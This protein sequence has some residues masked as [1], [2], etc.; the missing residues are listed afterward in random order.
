MRKHVLYPATDDAG[1]ERVSRAY[2]F[3]VFRHSAG[4]I[5]HAITRDLK[6]AQSLLRH[7]RIDTTA[8]IYVHVDE[9]V[10]EEATEALA[11]AIILNCG[12]LRPKAVIGFSR[13]E[14]LSP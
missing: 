4:S 8:D 5:V 2:G 7:S 10:A 1:I 6:M 9:A 3:H 14:G 13:H 12:L 11:K